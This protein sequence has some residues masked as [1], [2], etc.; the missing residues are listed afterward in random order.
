[1]SRDYAVIGAAGEHLV[2]SRL[3][4][5]GILAAK[6]PDG[7]SAVDIVVHQAAPD[8]ALSIAVALQ[9]KTRTRGGD[10]GWHMGQKHE[11]RIEPWLYYAFVDFEP[12]SPVVYVMPSAKVAQVVRESHATWLAMPGKQGQAHNDSKMRRIRP[13]WPFDVSSAPAGWMDQYREQWE[14]LGVQPVEVQDDSETSDK[15]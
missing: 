7:T 5:R 1:M 10:G 8:G 2:L 14:L 3:L 13:N 11:D 4:A 15:R 9:V 6:A 12:E